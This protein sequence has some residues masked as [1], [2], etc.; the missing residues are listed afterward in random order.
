VALLNKRWY[1]ARLGSPCRVVETEICSALRIGTSSMLCA[2]Y[3]AGDMQFCSRLFLAGVRHIFHTAFSAIWKQGK[4]WLIGPICCCRTRRAA[5]TTSATA[6]FSC[7][8]QLCI[9]PHVA[10][11]TLQALP[12]PPPSGQLP[13]ATH[14]LSPTAALTRSSICE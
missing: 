14:C 3:R 10:A 4:S 7:N 6:T 13:T 9:F 11:N 8:F 2:C 12:P 5:W 1:W